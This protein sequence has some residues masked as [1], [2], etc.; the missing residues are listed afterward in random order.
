MRPKR[1]PEHRPPHAES[2]LS[3]WVVPARWTQT[4]DERDA[5][6]AANGRDPVQERVTRAVVLGAL[7]LM[8]LMVV[9][10]ACG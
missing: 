2:M 1:P 6:R 5:L 10:M 8:V 3:A 9:R 4:E 7:V